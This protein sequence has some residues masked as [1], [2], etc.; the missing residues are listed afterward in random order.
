MIFIL[1]LWMGLERLNNVSTYQKEQNCISG[2]SLP[3]CTALKYQR[4]S[5]KRTRNK[6]HSW[7]SVSFFNTGKH[8][9]APC[10]LQDGFLG[11]LRSFCQSPWKPW[12]RVKCCLILSC[13][14]EKIVPVYVLFI[15][16]FLI[17]T[18]NNSCKRSFPVAITCVPI[19]HTTVKFCKRHPIMCKDVWRRSLK[20]KL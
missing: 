4:Q 10:C 2:S 19:L 3:I 5:Y 15:K 6:L 16:Y 18:Q 20:G 17:C 13:Q 1:C 11:H 9:R 14:E 7:L 8:Q 12:G